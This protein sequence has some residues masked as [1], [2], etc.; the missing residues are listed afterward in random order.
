MKDENKA[1]KKPIKILYLKEIEKI[2]ATSVDPNDEGKFASFREVDERTR[3]QVREI[4][5]QLDELRAKSYLK[6]FLSKNIDHEDHLFSFL[7]D[8]II[9]GMGQD[10]WEREIRK[11]H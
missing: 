3:S 4:Y 5:K 8:V 11:P 2:I 9:D 7:F 6:Y 10:E 1:D